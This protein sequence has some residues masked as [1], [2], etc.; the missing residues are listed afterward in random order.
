MPSDHCMITILLF[1]LHNYYRIWRLIGLT[2]RL[3]LSVSLCLS[4][5]VS[6]SVSACLSC[7]A[8]VDVDGTKIDGEC[9]AVNHS[10]VLSG[11]TTNSDGDDW[12]TSG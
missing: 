9:L 10:D 7:L 5:F 1:D 4:L 8:A 11:Q 12:V 2:D 6:L 3:C